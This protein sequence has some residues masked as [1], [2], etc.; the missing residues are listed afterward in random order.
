M[1]DREAQLLGP[2]A[3]DWSEHHR[4]TGPN[5]MDRQ[6]AKCYHSLSHLESGSAG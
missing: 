5:V 2:A 1:E 4:Q 3:S 6:T